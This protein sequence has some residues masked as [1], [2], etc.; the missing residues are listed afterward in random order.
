MRRDHSLGED[1]PD[2]LS[3]TGIVNLEM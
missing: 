3:L 1:M 2:F